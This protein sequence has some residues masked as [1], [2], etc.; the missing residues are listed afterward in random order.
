MNAHHLDIHVVVHDPVAYANQ[1]VPGRQVV[2]MNFLCCRQRRVIGQDGH[3]AP[4][5]FEPFG[6]GLTDSALNQ[7]LLMV[8]NPIQ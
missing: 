2:G 6:G 8:L 7:N 3:D 4:I 1:G 5:R